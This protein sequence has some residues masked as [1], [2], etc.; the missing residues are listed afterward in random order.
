MERE[1]TGMGKRRTAVVLA[2]SLLFMGAVVGAIAHG[3]AWQAAT[4]QASD[5]A[6][7]AEAA[8]ATTEDV[9]DMKANE[10]ARAVEAYSKATPQASG[11]CLDCHTS[12]EALE[13]SK[14]SDDVDV[15]HYLV[16]PDFAATT[17]GLLGC[18]YCHG[19]HPDDPTKDG[20]MAG[21]NLRPTADSGVSVCGECHGDVVEKFAT[22]LHNTTA[23]LKLSWD[24]RLA[25]ADE[26]LGV[27]LA[28]QYYHHGSYEG[29]C[30]DCHASCGECHVVS[31]EDLIDPNM[32]LLDG[33]NFVDATSNEDIQHTC[34]SCH[35][36]SITGCFTGYDVHGPAGAGMSCMDCHN[37]NEIHGD[38]VERSTMAHSGAITTECEDCHAVESL[39]GTWHNEG[40]LEA[41]ECWAC[42]SGTYNTC[43]NCHGWFAEGRGDVPFE[44]R[45]VL[46]LGYDLGNGKITTLVKAPVDGGMLGDST[47]ALT[48][49]D[50]LLNNGST[51][52]A[53][54]THGVIL[55]EANE[56][57]C[58]RCHGEG[59]NLLT[60][61]DLQ[62]PDYEREQVV[63][64]LPEVQP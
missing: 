28:G 45:D 46:C 52:Y 62:Y 44:S 30:I 61:A 63:A 9:S 7:A 2:A 43:Y 6:P 29:S 53:G 33:H 27:D 34:L 40:H 5:A 59:T 3:Q 37:I 18:T 56:E 26:A 39:E 54:F 60:E 64:P 50:E 55:P 32:G 38:G 24:N 20:A 47:T 8:A 23:G 15:S 25:D 21:A 22:S 51:W 41:N 4:A 1:H 19:G 42:H 16:D 10:I 35:A 36:G 57:F 49:P 12:A 31:V 48:I 11:T 14:S 58:S 13:A 17:H